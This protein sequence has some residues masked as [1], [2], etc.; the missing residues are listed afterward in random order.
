MFRHIARPL[1]AAVFVSEGIGA[2]RDPAP[3][4]ARAAPLVTAAAER[5]GTPDDPLLVV[6]AGAGVTIVGGVGLATGK[7]PRL[8]A[9][10]LATTLVPTTVAQHAFWEAPEGTRS[11]ELVQFLKNAGLLGGLLLMA[12][13]PS[14]R[15]VAHDNTRKV[16]KAASKQSRRGARAAAKVQAK[17][18]AS[19]IRTEAKLAAKVERTEAK[20]AAKKQTAEAALEAKAARLAA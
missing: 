1:L 5:F 13:P 16:R 14:L 9:L 18:E 4:V 12:D 3:R 6:R 15:A 8:S 2:L 20:L 19:A 7:A 17:A 11:E 10:A